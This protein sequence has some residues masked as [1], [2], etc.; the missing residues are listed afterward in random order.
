MKKKQIPMLIGRNVV[1]EALREG[2]PIDKVF[3]QQNLGGETWHE[4]SQ[5]ASTRAI[6]VSKVPV[7]K[8][9][10]LSR[11]N[12]QG[13]IAMTAPVA[14]QKLEDLIPFLYEKGITPLFLLL[15]GVT[16]VRNFGGI[17]RSAEVLG[18]H[19]IVIPVKNS[20][21]VSSDAVKTSAGALL[22][23]PVCRTNSWK[24]TLQTLRMNGIRIYG[25]EGK[26]N[27]LIRDVDW[28]QPSALILGA[29]DKGLSGDSLRHADDLVKIPQSGE[30][31]SLNVSVACGIILYEAA[32]QRGE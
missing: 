15:D 28:T 18:A 30:T 29:E 6:P 27:K 14:Y 19:A 25:A 20:A 17:A 16:D 3:I 21:P 5:L 24:A 31:E 10:R 9:D 26:A 7:Q 12:H 13:V 11:G 1:I 23:I 32:R 2:R 8:L 4:I 22:R